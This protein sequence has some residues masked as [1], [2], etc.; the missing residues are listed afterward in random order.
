MEEQKIELRSDEVQEILGTPPSWIVRWGT[1][2]A[3]SVVGVMA[4]AGWLLKYPDVISARVLLT[5]SVPPVEVIARTEGHISKL[6]VKDTQVVAAGDVLVLLQNTARFEDV[7]AL[8]KAVS[9]WQKMGIDS[10]QFVQAPRNLELGDLQTDYS[11]FAQN[12]ENL[13]FGKTEK[14]ESVQSNVGQI[15]AQIAKMR[16]SL[17]VDD[18]IKSKAERQV[19]TAEANLKKLGMLLD[20]GSISQLEYEREAQ[21]IQDMKRA[22]DALDEN[23]IRKENEIISLQKSIGELTFSE[24]SDASTV[25]VRLR[26]SLSAL[27][28]SLDKW[29]QT[30]LL[31]APISGK[32]SLNPTFFGEQQFVKQGDMV[33]TIVQS[34]DSTKILGRVSLPVAGSG[35]L[36]AGQRVIM[37]LDSYPYYEFGTVE[38]RVESKSLV[39]KD[40]QYVIFVSL[41]NGLKTSYQKELRF[42]QQLQGQAQIITEDKRFLQRIWEQVF[43]KTQGY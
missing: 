36:K 6:L 41:S 39:P 12:L 19:K 21:K 2:I 23:R 10:F 22:V 1:V 3:F 18:S 16:R 17:V 25:T 5:T 29:K 8:D 30:F 28:S 7:L 31:T 42:E 14:T 20:L 40:N 33:M 43:A 11:I 4:L 26:E 35:K 15:Q 24:K 32:V 38:G 27:R 34:A 13:R 37:R 9:A